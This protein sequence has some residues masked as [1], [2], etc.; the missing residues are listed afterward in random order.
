MAPTKV[1]CKFCSKSISKSN[2]SYHIKICQKNKQRDVSSRYKIKT[3]E[4]CKKN[5]STS[6]YTRHIK[7]CRGTVDD[8]PLD[9]SKRVIAQPQPSTSGLADEKGSATLDEHS[10]FE[11]DDSLS[12]RNFVQPEQSRPSIT[13][14]VDQLLTELREHIDDDLSE[15]SCVYDPL[16]P[17]N[18]RDESVVVDDKPLNLST[19][20]IVQ[21]EQS[22]P[23]ITNPVDQLSIELVDDDSIDYLTSGSSYHSSESSCVSD[24]LSPHNNRDESVDVDDIP[25]NLRLRGILY[26][27]SSLDPQ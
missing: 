6:F 15:F 24:P 19:R 18:N 27:P 10:K 8:T 13:N 4:K 20:N 22:R 5:I 2:I 12:T 25:L 9:L 1:N 3:C 26:N 23:S 17:H 21:S 11:T 7:T 16:S 14:P